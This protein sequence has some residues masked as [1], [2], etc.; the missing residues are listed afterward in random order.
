MITRINSCRVCGE[1]ELINF[2][3]LGEQPLANALCANPWEKD[4]VFPLSLSFC[5]KCSLIQL[6]HTISPEELF[7]NYVWV[8]STSSTARE[9]A[10]QFCAGLM[11][12]CSFENSS[13][14]LE[15]ASNDGTFL[16][17]FKK[18][19]LDVLGIDPAENIVNIANQDGV[20]THCAF[21]GTETAANIVSDKG[22]P[23]IIF[24]RNVLPHVADP[25]DF[26]K[27]LSLLMNE[28]TLLAIEVH[29]S[30]KIVEELHYDSIYHEHLCY[31]SLKSIQNLLENHGI[32][33]YDIEES[34]ISGGSIVVFASTKRTKKSANMIQYEKEEQNT[35]LNDLSTWQKFEKLSQQHKT[36][37]LDLINKANMNNKR[38]A[39]WG[40]SARSSTLLNFCKINT[41][42]IFGIADKNDLKHDMYSPGSHIPISSPD[43][44]MAL[45]PDAM[46]ILAWNFLD[47]IAY[48]LNSKYGF[49]G[50]IIIPFPHPPKAAT[51]KESISGK[52]K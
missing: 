49:N 9:Y 15:L 2:F 34:P 1:Q 42:S 38:L 46:V 32:Y 19:D 40:A 17:P 37:F 6:N 28:Q 27:G 16:K 24:A 10:Q 29:Y 22:I 47:E 44:I 5:P 31:F 25:N 41:D 35:R 21:F 7:S 3:D 30:G 50:R 26:V 13:Y 48:E 14:V 11:Q 39:A 12:R 33:I 51:I 20:L 52:L 36:N 43:K 4:S 45:Q 18:Y 23:D 8:T